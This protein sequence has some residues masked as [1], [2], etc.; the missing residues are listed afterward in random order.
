MGAQC[1]CNFS[2]NKNEEAAC[3]IDIIAEKPTVAVENVENRSVRK[4]RCS[5]KSYSPPGEVEEINASDV[6]EENGILKDKEDLNEEISEQQLE[7][8]K[9]KVFHIDDSEQK[10][11]L[12]NV[13]VLATK[14]Q[15]SD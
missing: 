15:K 3:E 2:S 5:E 7:K 9:R 4:T 10:Q 12:D 11:F 1:S 6:Y 14:L 13:S 8:R